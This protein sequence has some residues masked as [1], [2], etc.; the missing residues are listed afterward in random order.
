M[1]DDD[2]FLLNDFSCLINY[3]IFLRFFVVL[4]G[5]SFFIRSTRILFS[6]D[7]WFFCVS[8]EKSAL[9]YRSFLPPSLFSENL[10]LWG[11][12]EFFFMRWLI[13][14][15]CGRRKVR[16][17]I[18]AL[19]LPSFFYCGNLFL[20]GRRGFFPPGW[21]FVFERILLPSLPSWR[22]FFHMINRNF[23]N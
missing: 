14:S 8:A 19:F 13:S 4:C 5:K 20:Y 1:A 10:S 15:V 21:H 11:R 2:S 12:W 22:I 16:L 18:E 9:G 6:L 23:P 3:W 17:V 7:S